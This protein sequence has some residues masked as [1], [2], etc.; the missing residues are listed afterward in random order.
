MVTCFIDITIKSIYLFNF[1]VSWQHWC[2]SKGDDR[3]F[4]DASHR[5]LKPDMEIA[6]ILA[7]VILCSSRLAGIPICKILL[8]NDVG[9]LRLKS[10]AFLFV[11][12]KFV[13]AACVHCTRQCS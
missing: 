7:T 6:E 1:S 3:V 8:L 5:A 2:S 9:T 4:S 13:V 10:A 11:E 12:F